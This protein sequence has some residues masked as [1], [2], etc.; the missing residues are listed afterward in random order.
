MLS[1]EATWMHCFDSAGALLIINC[2]PSKLKHREALL[3]LAKYQGHITGDGST[4][5][6]VVNTSRMINDQL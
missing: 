2:S 5:W 4:K 6:R 3:M 1:A